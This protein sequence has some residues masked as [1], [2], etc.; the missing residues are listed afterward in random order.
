[1]N[2]AGDLMKLKAIM[3]VS[4]RGNFYNGSRCFVDRGLCFEVWDEIR[5]Y[6]SAGLCHARSDSYVYLGKIFQV[7]P[8]LKD[9]AFISY[10][11]GKSI[12]RGFFKSRVIEHRKFAVLLGGDHENPVYQT[13][14]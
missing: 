7:N 13:K 4:E 2:M 9:Q 14:L 8:H 10:I 5:G 12:S 3:I 1:M 6:A 11:R